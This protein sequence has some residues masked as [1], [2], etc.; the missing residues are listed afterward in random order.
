ML[1]VATLDATTRS[2]DRVC[3]Y[4]DEGGLRCWVILNA[5]RGQD[6]ACAGRVPSADA[7]VL[8]SQT[9]ESRRGLQ[10]RLLRHIR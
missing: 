7:I 2:P 10:R 1:R 5:A 6:C 9:D 4:G 8:G 3:H